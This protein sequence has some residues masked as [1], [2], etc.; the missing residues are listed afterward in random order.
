MQ[1]GALLL[2]SQPPKYLQWVLQTETQ[3]VTELFCVIEMQTWFWL[4]QATSQQSQDHFL[5]VLWAA[6]T[7]AALKRK[8]V[9]GPFFPW[10]NYFQGQKASAYHLW[11]EETQHLELAFV[12]SWRSLWNFQLENVSAWNPAVV[13]G[14]LSLISQSCVTGQCEMENRPWHFWQHMF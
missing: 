2:Q 7:T 5:H 1:P 12:S 8:Q 6:N 4:D 11:G 14:L 10:E 3:E 9:L 13:W